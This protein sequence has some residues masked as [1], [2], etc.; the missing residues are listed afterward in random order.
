MPKTGASGRK[1]FRKL[2]FDDRLLAFFM[3][4]RL[5]FP[6]R[7]LQSLFGVSDSSLSDYFNEIAAQ[8]HTHLVPRAF[9]LPRVDYM[10]GQVPSDF[11]Q[12]HPSILLIGD[13][14]HFGIQTPELFFGNGLTYSVYKGEN[15]FQLV[16]CECTFTPRSFAS[17]F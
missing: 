4:F 15:T 10:R 6:L 16:A 11:A 8:L 5:G 17:Y 13:G 2:Q 12:H 7:V 3:N 1:G 14:V 9:Y